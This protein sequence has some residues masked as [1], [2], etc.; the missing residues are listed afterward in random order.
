MTYRIV[1]LTKPVEAPFLVNYLRGQN[2]S[3]N[4]ECAFDIE[5]LREKLAGRETTTRLITFNCSVI[6]PEDVICTLGP[7]PYNVHPG[8]PEYPGAHPVAYALRDNARHYGATGHVIWPKVDAGPIVYY[9]REDIDADTDAANL[10][11]TAYYMAVK[12]FS[13]IGAHCARG[14]MPM[15]H[16]NHTWSSVKSTR[17]DYQNFCTIPD[18]ADS[19]EVARLRRICG[20]D[21]IVTD[22]A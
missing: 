8:P 17:E 3:L 5:G 14:D 21:L 11:E 22:V 2:P 9:K 7:E 10:T 12:A 19:E 4:I 15:P 13:V 6:V 18:N 1:I 16:L 20:N